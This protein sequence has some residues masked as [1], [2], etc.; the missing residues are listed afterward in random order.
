MPWKPL[1]MPAFRLVALASLI[2]AAEFWVAGNRVH[3]IELRAKQEKASATTPSKPATVSARRIEGLILDPDSKPVAGAIVVAA[4]AGTGK[5]NHRVLRADSS[6][7][8]TWSIIEG[9]GWLDFGQ[10]WLYFVAYK[11]GLSPGFW[12]R[13]MAAI[14]T[15]ERLELKLGTSEPCSQPS[16]PRR[17]CGRRKEAC[18]PPGF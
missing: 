1:Q 9:Q 14:R 11:E 3:A 16:H 17:P 8:F 13:P 5:A 2:V 6:G 12:D 7:S 4:I 15:G 10:E 18:Y